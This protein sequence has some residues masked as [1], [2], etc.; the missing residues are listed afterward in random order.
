MATIMIVEDD[1]SGGLSATR[2]SIPSTVRTGSNTLP[3]FPNPPHRNCWNAWSCSVICVL[4]SI[5]C[6]KRR[7]AGWMPV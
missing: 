1:I 7:A 4:R 2:H 3:A 5:P 6:L